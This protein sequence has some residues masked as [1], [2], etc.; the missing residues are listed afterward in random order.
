MSNIVNDTFSM[1]KPFNR[2]VM[3]SMFDGE[4]KW[5]IVC[6]KHEANIPASIRD[7]P[8]NRRMFPLH[9]IDVTSTVDYRISFLLSI[10]QMSFVTSLNSMT[11]QTFHLSK[12]VIEFPNRVTIFI[13]KSKRK[14][15][16]V[17]REF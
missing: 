14:I 5:W 16:I 2:M 7:E 12:K 4:K 9:S 11:Q 6:V 1:S 15:S 3:N 10:V 17:N 13:F 8:L